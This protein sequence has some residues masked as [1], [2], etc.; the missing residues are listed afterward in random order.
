MIHHHPQP[1]ALWASLPA[2]LV[3]LTAAAGYLLAV[4]RARRRNPALGWSPWRT[5]A[6]LTG[7]ALLAAALGPPLAPLAHGDFRGHMLQHMLL[8]MYAPL[9]LVLGAPVTLGLRTLP[10]RYARRLTRLLHRRPVRLLAAPVTALL[11]TV[12][13][14]AALYFTPLYDAVA[15]RPWAHP[16]LHAHFVAAGSLFAWAIAGPDPA[17]AR[18]PVPA[19][20]GVLGVAVAAH[21]TISQL[22][23][24]GYGTG[25]HVPAAQL[26]GAAEVMYYGGDIAEL[27]LAAALVATW[28]PVRRPRTAPRPA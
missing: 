2:L 5:G 15:R 23:Y 21:A 3:P 11:L 12:G 14:L 7:C 10:V 8:G 28:R 13:P 22:M 27:L 18:P 16:L 24:G 4:R 19:R 1:E 26:R 6:F 17:P 20:L 25:V 9:A